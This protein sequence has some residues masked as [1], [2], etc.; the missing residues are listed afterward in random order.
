MLAQVGMCPE[1]QV[2]LNAE[3]EPRT[4]RTAKEGWLEAKRG[5]ARDEVANMRWS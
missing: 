4:A 5:V 1:G 3:E 2:H